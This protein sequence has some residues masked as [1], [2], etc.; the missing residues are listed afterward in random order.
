MSDIAT[1]WAGEP[2]GAGPFAILPP[3][4]NEG[5]HLTFLVGTAAGT[6][7]VIPANRLSQFL[8]DHRTVTFVSTDAVRDHHRLLTLA[9]Q[10]EADERCSGRVWELAA[11][12]RLRDLHVMDQE[13]RYAEGQHGV[14]SPCPLMPRTTETEAVLRLTPSTGES[15]RQALSDFSNLTDRDA[16]LRRDANRP[17]TPPFHETHSEPDYDFPDYQSLPDSLGDTVFPV[18]RMDLRTHGPG[19]VERGRIATA[20]GQ[21]HPGL[22]DRAAVGDFLRTLIERFRTLSAEVREHAPLANAL[23]WDANGV[24]LAK[25]SGLVFDPVALQD[26]LRGEGKGLV[27]LHDYPAPIPRDANRKPSTDPE[28]WGPW[29][30]CSRPLWLWRELTRTAGLLD[31]A[32]DCSQQ[33]S[34]GP[35]NSTLGVVNLIAYRRQPI[36][37]FRSPP[38]SRFVIVRIPDLRF[39]TILS[40]IHADP[41]DAVHLDWPVFRTADFRDQVTQAVA[42]HEWFEVENGFPLL[43]KDSI[44]STDLGYDAVKAQQWKSQFAARQEQWTERVAVMAAI[45][46]TV[47]LGVHDSLWV[48]LLRNDYQLTLGETELRRRVEWLKKRV[49]GL[50]YFRED[51]LLDRLATLDGT[52]GSQ[53]VD[54]V[55]GAPHPRNFVANERNAILGRHSGVR[56]GKL[57]VYLAARREQGDANPTRRELVECRGVTLGDRVTPQGGPAVVRQWQ[58]LGSAEDALAEAA[59]TL[60]QHGWR[61]LWAAGEAIVVEVSAEAAESSM[62][63][64]AKLVQ[65]R[66]QKFLQIPVPVIPTTSDEW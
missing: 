34:A 66:A 14:A 37:V 16:R 62:L 47:G 60:S 21:H 53:V 26:W 6:T 17:R 10:S 43:A 36:R 40:L 1:V 55:F 7:V 52:T 28:R 41:Y 18:E 23:S 57:V 39:R 46:D 33:T 27:D 38:G 12:G 8:D 15:V 42:F 31:F 49:G 20:T 50:G 63:Q 35:W 30:G 5:P 58:V 48:R 24:K 2:L 4:S 13:V 22:V 56:H 54:T 11:S 25:S 9:T 32:F 59:F 65:Q 64:I 19:V 44:R 61:V 29:I 51:D 3:A 45:L